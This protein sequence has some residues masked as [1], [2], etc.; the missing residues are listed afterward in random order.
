MYYDYDDDKYYGKR[1]IGNLFGE[2]D[3]VY[4]KP[5]KTKSAFDGNYT[6]YESKGDKDKNV[7]L[8]EYLYMIIPYLRDMINTHKLL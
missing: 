3:E 5:I 8:K 6:E 4:Y 2:I 1:E 7:S